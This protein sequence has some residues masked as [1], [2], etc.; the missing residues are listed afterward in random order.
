[1]FHFNL[2][3]LSV[4]FS[5]I[6]NISLIPLLFRLLQV[7]FYSAQRI[8]TL[9]SPIPLLFVL[10]QVSLYSDN[11]SCTYF[12][13][14]HCF[15]FYHFPPIPLTI[16]TL[17]HPILLLFLL[18]LASPIP[19]MFLTPISPYPYVVLL[20]LVFSYSANDS[21]TYFLLSLCC[22]FNQFPL[23][24]PLLCLLHFH[25]NTKATR[26]YKDSNKASFFFRWSLQTS[27]LSR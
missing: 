25:P 1:M 12:H 20:L 10:S 6:T 18:L 3:H 26:P 11:D 9:M 23:P 2:C 5:H 21:S 13:L 19:L 8:L 27:F 17:M 15:C 4:A 22:I 16:L 14:S 24:I 7:S